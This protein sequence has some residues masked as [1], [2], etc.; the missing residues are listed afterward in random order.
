MS[1]AEFSSR[2]RA[3]S[4]LIDAWTGGR[5]EG[6]L[7]RLRDALARACCAAA[8][9]LAAQT[10][11]RLVS[12]TNDGYTETYAASGRDPSRAVFDA[13]AVYLVNTGLLS[14]WIL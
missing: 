1:E 5:A 8:D 13:A 3:A 7:P 2:A 6:S 4:A 10:A 12:V 9:A 11:S 14:S